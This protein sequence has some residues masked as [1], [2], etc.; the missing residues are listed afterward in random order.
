MEYLLLSLSEHTLAN[1]GN[2]EH[3]VDPSCNSNSHSQLSHFLTTVLISKIFIC[4]SFTPYF[5]HNTK[6]FLILVIRTLDTFFIN[7]SEVCIKPHLVHPFLLRW[8]GLCV[9]IV[10]RHL[11]HSHVQ[12]TK[13][14][15]EDEKLGYDPYCVVMTSI[16]CKRTWEVKAF[17]RK[18]PFLTLKAIKNVGLGCYSYLFADEEGLCWSG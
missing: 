3:N 2:G 5:Y 8:A 17:S 6:L 11:C 10:R 18:L 9:L 12:V 14:P 16:V 13:I 1:S 7:L 15:T 4:L